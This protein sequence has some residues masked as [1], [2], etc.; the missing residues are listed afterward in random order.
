MGAQQ[1]RHEGTDR[2]HGVRPCS[3]QPIGEARFFVAPGLKNEIAHTLDLRL[4]GNAFLGYA[5]STANF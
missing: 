1:Q 4:R 3:I 5:L 2:V